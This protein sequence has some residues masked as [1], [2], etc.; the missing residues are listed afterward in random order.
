M[1]LFIL[2]S[3]VAVAAASYFPWDPRSSRNTR[4]GYSSNRSVS[5]DPNYSVFGSPTRPLT[6]AQAEVNE[7]KSLLMNAEQKMQQFCRKHTDRPLKEAYEANYFRLYANLTGCQEEGLKIRAGQ[8]LIAVQ[9]QD[10]RCNFIALKILP[11]GVDAN[12][13]FWRFVKGQL[14]I[15]FPYSPDDRR[16]GR[17]ISKTIHSLPKVDDEEDDDAPDPD[18][19]MRYGEADSETKQYM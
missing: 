4:R 12:S 18:M 11:D 13:A 7:I 6:S 2:A 8:R 3:L 15:L 9:T 5:P 19:D 14:D 10:P 16:C 1:R 17:V